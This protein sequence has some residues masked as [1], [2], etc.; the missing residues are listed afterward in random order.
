M[1]FFL[2]FTSI[3]NETVISSVQNKVLLLLSL[4]TSHMVGRKNKIMNNRTMIPALKNNAASRLSGSS[5]KR[6]F[7][8]L[9]KEEGWGG[10]Q[11]TK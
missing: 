6:A 5:E 4:A 8:R 2:Y 7:E 10:T 3:F 9:R 11:T 1:Y